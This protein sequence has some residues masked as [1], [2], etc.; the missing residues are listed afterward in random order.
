MKIKVCGMKEAANINAVADL[1]PD[2]MGFIFYDG[3]AR[4]IGEP[5]EIGL[6]SQ[7]LKTGVFVDAPEAFVN[8]RIVRY[9]LDAVQFHGSE[10]PAYCDEFRGRV[11][12]IKAAGIDS[13]YR[14]GHLAAFENSVDIFL[15]DRKTPM[16]GGS[17]EAFDWSLLDRYEMDIPFFLSGGIGPENLEGVKAVRHPAFY[18][19]DLNS[20]FELQPGLKD[21]EKLRA[22]FEK[23]RQDNFAN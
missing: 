2:Y 17:G 5:E 7:I 12:V 4:Y 23:L 14:F 1:G 3:S 20:R 9:G 22:A 16:H 19:L 11:L 21:V 18:G 15:F 6:A 10:N 8:D 13:D